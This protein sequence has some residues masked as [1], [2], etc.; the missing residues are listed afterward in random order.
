MENKVETYRK[1]FKP[2][3]VEM[4]VRINWCW[5]KGGSKFSMLD[6]YYKV[7]ARFDKALIVN[8]GEVIDAGFSFCWLE[9]LAP[10]KLFGFQYGYKFKKGNMYR[11]LAREYISKESDKFKKYYIEQVLEENVNEPLLDSVYNFE[12]KYEEA[13]TDI[14][15]LIKKRIFCWATQAGYRIPGATFLA[16]IDNQTGEFSETCGRLTWIEKERK[17]DIRFN[18]DDMGI[19]HVKVRKGKDNLNSYLLVDVIKKVKDHRLEEVKERYLTPV[20]ITNELGEFTLDR[21]FNHFK[22]QADYLGD[23]CFVYMNVEEGETT[24]GVQTEVLKHIF[25]DLKVWDKSIREYA[26][27]KLSELANDWCEQDIT[28][29]EFVQ[30]IGVPDITIDIDGSVEVMFDSDGMFTDHSIVIDIDENGNFKK[31]GIIG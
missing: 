9:W 2:E 8:T 26:F 18:F 12:A 22:G 1:Q 11:I 28:K 16:F 6:N 25:A 14:T 10:K 24:V 13:I 5:E 27:E 17:A 20:V 30:R 7:Q 23:K 15:V 21:N 4:I 3:K 31:A 19:Y 29:E